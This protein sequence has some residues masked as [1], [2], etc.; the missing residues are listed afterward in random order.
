MELTK[1]QKCQEE[2]YDFPY[3]YLDLKSNFQKLLKG[4]EYLTLLNLVKDTLSPFNK[5]LILDAGC[6]DGRLCY[7]LKKENV[8]VV[9]I[10]Y[11]HKAINFAKAFNPELEFLAQDLEHPLNLPY[12]FDKIVLM[13]VLEHFIPEKIQSILKNLSSVLKEDGKLVITVPSNNLPLEKKHYQHFTPKSLGKTIHP[14]FGIET[15]IGYDKNNYQK[16]LFKLL[17][18]GSYILYPYRKS[19]LAKKGFEFIKEYYEKNVT[20]GKL[21]ECNGLIAVCTKLAK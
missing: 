2:Q 17:R 8:K 15:I 7:E 14:Y 1:T 16:V 5:E 18:K 3:H 6:G 10:D 21:E 9:G 13:E 19:R 11:S 20:I 4:I 12:K